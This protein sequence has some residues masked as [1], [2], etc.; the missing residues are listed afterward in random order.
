MPKKDRPSKRIL[1]VILEGDWGGQIYLVVQKSQVLCS[2]PQ[3]LQLL[4]DL[5]VI[6]WNYNDGN[7]ASCYEDRLRVG[8]SVFGGMGGGMVSEGVWIH[9]TLEYFRAQIEAVLSGKSERIAANDEDV[10]AL[11][12]ERQRLRWGIE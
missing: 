6:C 3:L 1:V 4:R 12:K 11:Q 5:D 9:S 8:A 10:Q 2:D 7:G